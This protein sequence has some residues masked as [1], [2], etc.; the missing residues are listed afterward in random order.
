MCAQI[1]RLY[2]PAM[3]PL[4]LFALI[5]RALQRRRNR[6]AIKALL[7]RDDYILCDLGYSRTQLSRGL[8]EP[9]VHDGRAGVHRVCSRA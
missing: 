4:W 8:N 2:T 3:P 1:Q 5:E 9:P 6:R 7:E